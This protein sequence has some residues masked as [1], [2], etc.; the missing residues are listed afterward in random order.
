[1][2][3]MLH[4]ATTRGHANQGWLDSW[5]TFSFAN[6][7]DPERM[8]FGV[9]RVLNDDTV[10]PGMGFGR[11]PHDNMEIISIPLE[12]DLEHQDSMGNKQV[13]RQGDVQAMSA[14]RGITHSEKNKNN[15]TFVK[16][17][18]IWVFPNKRNVTPR[19]DQK[20]FSEEEKHNKLLTVVSPM[21]EAEGVNIYQDAWFS[22]GKLDKD[23]QIQYNIKKQDNGVYAF[24]L[25]GDATIND[26]ALNRRDG[27]GIWDTDVLTIKADTNTELLLMDVPMH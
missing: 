24:V 3:T 23:Q 20:A 6:Y 14:G 18:Q 4:K 25:E 9:L 13:I 11:H 21:G 7:Y 15:D 16:F 26:I 19:Y 27:L 5:H 2:E 12:G 8:H 1:M 22:L 17:L 10:A